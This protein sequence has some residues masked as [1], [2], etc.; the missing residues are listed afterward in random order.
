MHN[1]KIDSAGTAARVSLR[2]MDGEGLSGRAL[3]QKGGLPRVQVP[4]FKCTQIRP[5]HLARKPT[6]LGGG[7]S[8]PSMGAIPLIFSIRLRTLCKASTYGHAHAGTNKTPAEIHKGEQTYRDRVRE[9]REK[10]QN[11]RAQAHRHSVIR[12]LSKNLERISDGKVVRQRFCSLLIHGS[13]VSSAMQFS[14][15]IP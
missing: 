6:C 13:A 8:K 5:V 12:V 4:T 15:F 9:R 2:R 3:I 7:S 10:N 11:T 14:G 1:K